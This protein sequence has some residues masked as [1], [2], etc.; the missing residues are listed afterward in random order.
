[1]LLSV[2]WINTVNKDVDDDD[3]NENKES[4][5]EGADNYNGI[6]FGRLMKNLRSF[7]RILVFSFTKGTFTT[8]GESGTSL[9]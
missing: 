6:T 1:M 3:K 9:P 8:L 4:N 2:T 7:S 5:G